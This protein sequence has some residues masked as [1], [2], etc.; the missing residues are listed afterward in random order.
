[1]SGEHPVQLHLDRVHCRAICE[2]IGDRLRTV[3]DRT[4]PGLPPRL[5]VLLAALEAQ[6]LNSPSI[7]PSIEDMQRQTTMDFPE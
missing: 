4:Q 5:K 7:V 6:D 2:E 1:M 3:L